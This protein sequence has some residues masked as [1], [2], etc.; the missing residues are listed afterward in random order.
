M[1]NRS[2]S[3]YVAGR[4]EAAAPSELGEAEQA[5]GGLDQRT[6][7]DERST[8]R[9]RLDQP[10]LGER[11][12]RAAHGRPAHVQLVA[13]APF[14]G[15]LGAGRQVALGDPLGD[16]PVDAEVAREPMV[17]DGRHVGRVS[18]SQVDQS[19]PLREFRDHRSPGA[20]SWSGVVSS[21]PRWPIP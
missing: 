12:E 14:G 3:S 4:P 11:R 1:R 20:A 15:E 6:T 13:Q 18:R 19:R 9:C 16:E 21:A 10:V 17:V 7:G 2:D 8:P 5:V